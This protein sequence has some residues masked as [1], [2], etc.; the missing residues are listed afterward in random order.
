MAITTG[1]ISQI[2]GILGDVGVQAY[3]RQ[4]R[5]DMEARFASLGAEQQKQLANKLLNAKSDSEK[6]N[7]L[8]S[9]YLYLQNQPKIN[10]IQKQK[11]LVLAFI[12]FG[13]IA[14][15]FVIYKAIKK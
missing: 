10:Q 13:V 9:T 12:G 15:T 6:L 11:N 3:D 8:S 14:L 2:I 1:D 7:I 4:Q 5:R